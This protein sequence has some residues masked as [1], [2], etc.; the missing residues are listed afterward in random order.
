M[1]LNILLKRHTGRRFSGRTHNAVRPI[2][3]PPDG[4]FQEERNRR[5]PGWQCRPR[6]ALQQ[7]GH[8]SL[9][10]SNR[11]HKTYGPVQFDSV[12]E[13]DAASTFGRVKLHRSV[14]KDLSDCNLGRLARW[15]KDRIGGTVWYLDCELAEGYANLAPAR[16]PK[17]LPRLGPMVKGAPG[18]RPGTQHHHRTSDAGD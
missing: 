7:D 3:K 10:A 14:Q 9:S 1:L 15:R 17:A 2:G 11:L 12:R 6:K 13:L 8:N 5:G 18:S 16:E 4:G